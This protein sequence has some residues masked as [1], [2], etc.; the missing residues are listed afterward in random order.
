MQ[1]V[2]Y[3]PDF[4]IFVPVIVT[5]GTFDGFHRGHQSLLEQM[6]ACKQHMGLATCLLTFD[7]HPRNVINH[8]QKGVT[9]LTTCEEKIQLA[10]SYN[11]DILVIYPF[12]SAFS[13]WS[14]EYFFT[15]LIVNQ[16]NARHVIMGY[17]HRFGKDR[18]GDAA[19]IKTLALKHQIGVETCAAVIDE[20]LP[21]SSTRIRKALE[22][23]DL[24][25]T[26]RLLGY[27]YQLWGTVIHGMGRG[28]KNG[29][30]T[31]NIK[32]LELFK[33]LPNTGVYLVRGY[34]NNNFYY[35]MLNIGTNPTFE[36]NAELKIEVH[37]FD[38][39][40]NLY[41]Q[42]IRIEFLEYIRSV[43]KFESSEALYMQIRQDETVCRKKMQRYLT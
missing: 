18:T 10:K 4:K 5:I 31:A 3:T 32:P 23:R 12:N 7:P 19:Y 39:S 38:F 22:L 21:I 42:S 37:F 6:S 30:P 13:S 20:G 35:G 17:D 24:N 8:D 25:I 26:N 15:T 41:K 9:L 33:C 11:I 28:H 14:P 34:W 40:S 43:Q 27:F 1:V 2:R 29:Y 36:T 16:L